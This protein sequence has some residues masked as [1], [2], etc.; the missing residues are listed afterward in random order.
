M[1]HSPWVAVD[2]A[3]IPA[4]RARELRDAWEDFVEGRSLDRS[5]GAG[6][7]DVRVPIADSWQ[8]SVDAGVDPSGRQP[9]PSLVELE[10][11]RELWS[12]H[13]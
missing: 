4:T 11:A 13:P 12:V 8:R 7:P 3:T 2:A 9:A 6:T 10:G 5:E 1:L